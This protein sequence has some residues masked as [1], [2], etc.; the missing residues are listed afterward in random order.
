[1]FIFDL[2]KTIKINLNYTKN[3]LSLNDVV[4]SQ[5]P[6]INKIDINISTKKGYENFKFV[7]AK[8]D[9][10]N[11][12]LLIIVG[13]N[14]SVNGYENKY[15]K[16]AK[17]ANEIYGNTVFIVSNNERNWHSAKNCFNAIMTYLREHM[18]NSK[19]TKIKL[20]G[21]S[22]GAT[23]ASF[24]A[25]EYPE[26]TDMLLVN[27]PLFRENME[28]TI[29]AIKLFTGNST[30]IIGKKDPSYEFGELFTF[31]NYANIFNNV[32]LFDN[33]D[34]N[35]KGMINEFIDLPFRYLYNGIS[36]YA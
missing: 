11:D 20:F 35:F 9:G 18:S 4:F 26:I 5:S 10:K 7:V 27:P 32:I 12:I 2:L 19:G 24:Y 30:L 21:V 36:L 15:F 17:R 14:G 29:K 28:L 25:W 6:E 16:I 31:D 23:L 22:A 1:L 8:I 3:Q 13:S 34:H 33:A